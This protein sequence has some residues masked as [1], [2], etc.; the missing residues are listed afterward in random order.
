MLPEEI[1][2][3]GCPGEGQ[4]SEMKGQDLLP[5]HGSLPWLSA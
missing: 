5:E 2:G 1:R 4:S 3:S